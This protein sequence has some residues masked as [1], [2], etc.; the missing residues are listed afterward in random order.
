MSKTIPERSS[1]VVSMLK[2]SII[3]VIASNGLRNI[4][5]EM[6]ILLRYI[7]DLNGTLVNAK[8][9]LARDCGN[10]KSIC[11]VRRNL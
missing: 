7:I 10:S 4:P 9:C 8:E 3:F 1:P 6:G 2:E 11:R 5:F